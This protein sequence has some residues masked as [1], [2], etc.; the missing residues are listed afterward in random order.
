M[1]D[2]RLAELSKAAGLSVDWVDADGNAQAVK[3]EHQRRLLEALGY[4]AADDE[5]IEASLAQVQHL[6]LI[7][8]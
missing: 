5:Q 2:A 4:P 3:P 1:S 8:I 6:S 7:H